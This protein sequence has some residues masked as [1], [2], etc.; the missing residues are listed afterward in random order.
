MGY[1]EGQRPEGYITINPQTLEGG[2]TC[3]N[4]LVMVHNA[5]MLNVDEVYT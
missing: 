4:Q 2:I 1:Y 3:I 5:T